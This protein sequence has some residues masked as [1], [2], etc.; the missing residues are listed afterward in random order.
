MKVKAREIERD[1]L[2]SEYKKKISESQRERKKLHANLK[3]GTFAKELLWKRLRL[4]F[5]QSTSY[6]PTSFFDISLLPELAS[7]EIVDRHFKSLCLLCLPDLGRRDDYFQKLVEARNVL[8]DPEARK[9]WK[10]RGL[11]A[12]KDVF[13]HKTQ[14]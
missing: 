4:S 14:T 3:A 9:V 10:K 5:A 1:S 7:P 11:E 6:A 8:V 13:R 12:A 2:D